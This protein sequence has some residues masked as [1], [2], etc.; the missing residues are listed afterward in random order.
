M[1][2]AM[3]GLRTWLSSCVDRRLVRA[4]HHTPWPIVGYSTSSVW[5]SFLNRNLP[6]SQKG[7]LILWFHFSSN[8]FRQ[9]VNLFVC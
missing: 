4:E 6:C 2:G 8:Y 1:K 5:C 3:R 9:K 7:V